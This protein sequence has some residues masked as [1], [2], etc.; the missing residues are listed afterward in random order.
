MMHQRTGLILLAAMWFIAGTAQTQT[1]DG[2]RGESDWKTAAREKVG[3]WMHD[4]RIPGAAI[5][6]SVNGR[7]IWSEGFGFADL[8]Q[9]VPVHPE[10]TRFRIASI[11]KP[12]TSTGLARLIE[13]GKI[14]PDSSIAHYLPWFPKKKYRPTVRQ[15]AGH[16]GG[17]R[18]YRGMENFSQ[19]RY[20]DVRSGVKIFEDDSLLYKP[21]TAYVYSS[22]GYNLL[23]AVM[24]S[25]SGKP[26]L[27]FMDEEVL[28][29]L[30]MSWTTADRLDSII[31]FRGRY[32]ERDGRPS[33]PV[34]NSYKWAG[35]G[36][37]STAA[38]LIRFGNGY[39]QTS[40]LKDVT[41]GELTVSQKLMNGQETGYGMGW[42]T[43]RDKAGRPTYGHSG[44]AVGGTSQLLIHPQAGVVLVI[45]T[46]ASGAPISQLSDDLFNSILS[47]IEPADRRGRSNR[48][49]SK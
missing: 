1:K 33:P 3:R 36:Y 16:T 25:A 41:I 20:P 37:L 14:H 8:E 27:R 35:G 7:T 15:V 32:Y 13:Q 23:S 47:G 31:P 44:G 26:Y 48:V 11:S 9:H 30:G 40:L 2:I 18:H 22:Y 46:N 5:A 10:R 38:D 34:D 28:R 21:G 6:A 39:L 42:A 45:L 29:P 24:E 4:H 19:T 43:G 17:I 12:L 49:K